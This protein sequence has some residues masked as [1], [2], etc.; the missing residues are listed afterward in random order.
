M[1]LFMLFITLFLKM[2]VLTHFESQITVKIQI[3]TENA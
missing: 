3:I 1:D 2:R